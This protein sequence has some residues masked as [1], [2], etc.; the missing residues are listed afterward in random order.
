MAEPECD[1]CPGRG[2]I[3]QPCPSCGKQLTEEQIRAIVRGDRLA[4]APR[5][6]LARGLTATVAERNRRCKGASDPG[7]AGQPER[8]V[9]GTR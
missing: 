5:A 2:L 9:A 1:R 4:S 7:R 8:P 3:F 6:C